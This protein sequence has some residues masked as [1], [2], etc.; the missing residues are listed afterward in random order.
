MPRLLLPI[1]KVEGIERGADVDDKVVVI[2][3]VSGSKLLAWSSSCTRCVARGVADRDRTEED[4]ED[5]G[6]DG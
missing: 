3:S 1:E 4:E 2:L 5:V 6:D